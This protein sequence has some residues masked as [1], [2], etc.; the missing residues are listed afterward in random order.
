MKRKYSSQS[1]SQSQ[2]SRKRMKTSR[3]LTIVRQPKYIL[4]QT[5]RGTLVYYDNVTLS[6]LGAATL[7][8]YIFSANG[9]YDP[10][11][12]GTGHQ[13]RGFDQV[14]AMYDHY[15]VVGSKITV[16]YQNVSTG[17]RPYVGISLRDNTTTMAELE[18]AIEYSG[19]IASARPLN[20]LSTADEA[21][22]GSSLML[23]SKCNPHRFLGRMRNDPDLRGNN[24]TN[25]VE[26]AFYH[27]WGSDPVGIAAGDINL[28][29]KIEYSV[30]YSEPKL[31]GSS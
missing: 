18:D 13:P 15:L 9:C 27:I 17:T 6:A 16:R 4:G 2:R 8:T 24:A 30:L 29:V 26:Q 12:T 3:K 11:I 31:P 23:T 19:T 22:T 21:G 20:R 25:P 10:N 28:I 7:G 5:L 1:Q 14:M